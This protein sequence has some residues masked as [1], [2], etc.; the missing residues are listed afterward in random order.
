VRVRVR[1]V[2]PRVRANLDIEAAIDY[3]LAEGGEAAAL[4]FVDALEIA[5]QRIARH[6]SS[7]SP[8][9]AGELDLPGLGTV[10]LRRY[11]YLVFYLEG[12]DRVDV[13]RILHQER[14][15]PQRMHEAETP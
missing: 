13:W 7:G 6:A 9:F 11:S 10:A 12:E 4:G 5:F 14:D 8:R 15:L 1:P 2:T 3:Y